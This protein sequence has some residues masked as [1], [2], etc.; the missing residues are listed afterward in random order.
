[1]FSAVICLRLC[2]SCCVFSVAVLMLCFSVVLFVLW[3]FSAVCLVLCVYCCVFNNVC[4]VLC[5]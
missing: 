4:L 3:L 1:M 2:V 5:V